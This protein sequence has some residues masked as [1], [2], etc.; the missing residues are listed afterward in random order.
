MTKYRIVEEG[1]TFTDRVKYGVQF[2]CFFFWFNFISPLYDTYDEA[3]DAINC[4]NGQYSKY[5]KL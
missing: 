2:R 4:L 1:N 3:L 5:H